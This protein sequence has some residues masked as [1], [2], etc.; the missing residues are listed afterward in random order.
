VRIVLIAHHVAPIRAPFIGGVESFTWNL[1]RWLAD[2]GHDVVAYAPPGSDIPGVRMRDLDLQV[3]LSDAARAD[4]DM[5]PADFMAA[6][7]A[8]QRLMLELRADPDPCDVVHSNTLHYMP[9]LMADT[10]GVPVLTT[11]HTPP[12]PWLESALRS[13]GRFGRPALNAVSPATRAAWDDVVPELPVV[14][15]GVDPRTWPAGRGGRGAVW[16]GR[17]VPE[18]A[19]HLAIDACREAGLPLVLAG[20]IIDR[21]YWEAEVRPRLGDDTRYVGHL[22][23]DELARELGSA[24]VALMTPAWD[25][26]FGLVAAEAMTCGTPVAAFARGGLPALIGTDGG[27]LALPG[28]VSDLA[29]AVRDAARMDRRAV[30]AHAVRTAGIEA[31]GRAYEARYAEIAGV[32]DVLETVRPLRSRRPASR[33]RAPVVPIRAGA[34]AAS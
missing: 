27:R 14:L 12:T 18:K 4:V 9:L 23:H 29:R 32:P 25:E 24:R 8:Y 6:H 3:R 16:S 26:P 33:R 19:P 1:G 5:P 20:P 31:M 11:L 2:R 30:R 10:I 28:D 13:L 21:A 22:D 7:H 17:I 34:Q 15:N